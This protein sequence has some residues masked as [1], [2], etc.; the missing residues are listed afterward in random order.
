MAEFIYR[1]FRKTTIYGT[2]AQLQPDGRIESVELAPLT[3]E[4]VRVDN[5]KRALALLAKAFPGTPIMGVKWK[6]EGEMYRLSTEDFKKYGEK[7][8]GEI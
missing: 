7:V 2:T 1:T 5:Q 8:E 3:L 6:V 4:N